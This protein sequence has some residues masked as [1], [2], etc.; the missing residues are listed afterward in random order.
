MGGTMQTRFAGAVPAMIG[1]AALLLGAVV[2]P[3]SHYA[4][5]AILMLCAVG[6]YFYCALVQAK[7]NW[8]DIRAVFSAIWLMTNGLA[9]LRLTGYQ[10]PWETKTWVC[11]AIAFAAFHLG[12]G[13][14]SGLGRKIHHWLDGQIGK[15]MGRIRIAL[16]QER[17]FWFC[18]AV[19]LMGVGAFLM[20]VRSRGFIPYLTASGG[21]A[22]LSFYTKWYIFAVAG[23][24][25][26]GLSYY[27]LKTQKLSL[28]KRMFLWCSIL[29]STF[30]F[31]ILVVNRSALL[32]AGL[33]LTTAVFYLNKRRLWVLVL[34]AVVL[35]GAFGM[36]TSA[37]GYSEAQLQVFFEPAQIGGN[38]NQQTEP[39]QPEDTQP[40][41]P[42]ETLQPDDTQPSAPQET[43]Q[44][45]GTP[46]ETAPQEQP[47]QP[48]FQ[49]SGTAAFIYS[50]LTVSHDNL[51]EAMRNEVEFTYGARQLKPFNVILRIPALANVIENAEIYKVRPHLTTVNVIGQ[52]YYDFGLLG[53]GV[54]MFL[55]AM[56]F[57][58]I[59]AVYLQGEGVFSMLALGNSMTPVTLCFFSAWMSEF[60]HWMHWGL[61]LI[62]FLAAYITVEPRKGKE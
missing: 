7:G 10:A 21:S 35:V 30:L 29:Y 47:Q 24:M 9:A 33:S 23:S 22:Y 40:P 5:A 25:I 46:Q 19:T 61:I 48:G 20:N 44:P 52:A 55:W 36:C 45:E 12:A 50:Y 43:V 16:R 15:S 17:L 31:P 37:R 13:L 41:V 3:V 26:S 53:V 18:F 38:N 60:S 57:G 4:A 32:T 56:I 59:Q 6:L 28:W 34:C 42:Q 2:S 58:A 27:V 62:L 11:Q 49:L 51:N 54:F 8:W 14:G 1:T 39:N